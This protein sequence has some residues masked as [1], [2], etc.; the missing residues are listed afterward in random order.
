MS[1]HLD[2]ETTGDSAS[3]EFFG[4]TWH[5]PTKQRLSHI[6]RMR[7]EMRAGVPNLDLLLAELFLSPEELAALYEIDPDRDELDK[8]GD[9][10]SRVMGLGNSGNSQP[11]S[12]S[13]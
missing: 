13:S 2:H 8:F 5:V 10:I 7:D 1:D 6:R 9:E 11:S 4:R 3:F 12:A